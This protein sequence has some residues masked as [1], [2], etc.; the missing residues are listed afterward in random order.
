MKI[1]MVAVECCFNL[2]NY[3]NQRFRL[4]AKLEDGDTAAAVADALKH[5]IHLMADKEDAY[6]ERNKLAAEVKQLEANVEAARAEW[7]Q[8]RAFLVAQGLRRD[9]PEFPIPVLRSL[10]SPNSTTVEIKQADIFE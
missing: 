9:A 10:P 5:Q 2:G 3:E 1:T 8:T 6:Y 4:E 7:E